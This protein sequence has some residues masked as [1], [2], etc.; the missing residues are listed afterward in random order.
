M[1]RGRATAAVAA[2]AAA[3]ALLLTGCGPT[4]AT[5]DRA[6]QS[7]P[8]GGDSQLKDMQQK[9]DAADSAAAEADSD[10]TQNN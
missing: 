2:L 8:G 9:V 10:A 6:A 4:A 7:A 1:S 5:P 3:A